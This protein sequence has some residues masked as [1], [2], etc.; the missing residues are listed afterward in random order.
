MESE[1]KEHLKRVENAIQAAKAIIGRHRYPDDIRSVIVMGLID[2]TREDHDSVLL[3]IR[4]GFAGSAFALARGIFE[5]LYR[6]LWFNAC[7][8]DAEVEQFE[9]CDKYPRGLT[10][11]EMAKVIDGKYQGGNFFQNFANTFWGPLC[12][13]T[14]TGMLQLGHRFNEDKVEGVYSDGQISAV[15]TIATNCF[16]MLA[17]RFLAA[18]HHGEESNAVE[19]LRHTYGP[20]LA[21]KRGNTGQQENPVS[22]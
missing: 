13:Y 16:L 20:L 18:Q 4:S 14:H 12:S 5:S 1:T 6:G 10:M 8:T 7:A 21:K 19:E 11:Q 9:K 2:Q 17:G 3:L 22:G 15:T